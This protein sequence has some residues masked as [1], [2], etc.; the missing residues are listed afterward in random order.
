M[1][2]NAGGGGGASSATTTGAVLVDDYESCL[3]RLYG[4]CVEIEVLLPTTTTTVVGGGGT[5][6]RRLA[7]RA[8]AL[9]RTGTTNDAGGEGG[10]PPPS[11]V[12]RVPIKSGH[13]NPSGMV[14]KCRASVYLYPG[15][16]T[17]GTS[18]TSHPPSAAARGDGANDEVISL[19]LTNVHLP[20]GPAL[21]DPSWSKGRRVFWGGRAVGLI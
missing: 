5:M 15:G 14:S 9:V 2:T 1:A 6:G 18:T 17:V 7:R 4:K 19:G 13:V 8:M 11:I 16:R 10:G 20:L 3:G 21:I 12:Y